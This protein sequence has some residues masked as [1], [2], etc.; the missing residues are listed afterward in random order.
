MKFLILVILFFVFSS[1][2]FAENI[3]PSKGIITT[4]NPHASRAALEIIEKGGNSIDAAVAVQLVLTLTEPQATGIGGGAFML[5]WDKK[6]SKL[7][8]IDGREKAPSRVR[9]DLFLDSKGNKKRFYPDAVV[10][11]QS[12]GVP[13]VIRLLEESHKKFGKLPWDELFSYAIN[14]AEN[15]FAVSPALN[16]ILG[17]LGPLKKIEPA[18]SLYYIENLDGEKEPVPV[19]YKLKN[20]EYSKT[21]K[22]L[23]KRGSRDFYEGET[24]KLIIDSI[25]KYNKE[26]V[27]SH[28]DLKNYK[29]V[30]REPLCSKY[31]KYNVCSMGPPS[32]G[33]L[34]ML[35]MLKLLEDFNIESLKPNSIDMIHLFSEVNRIAY[36]DRAYYMGDSDFINVPINGLLD[37]TYIKKRRNL[38]NKDYYSED[39]KEG[40]PEGY[41]N[42]EKNID[43]SKPST[44]HFVI[45]DK[46]GNA[47]SMTSTVEGPFG[48]HLMAGGFILNNELTD[49]SMLPEI[50]GKKIANR[51]E[52]NK[53]P[54]SSMTPTIIFK[55]NELYALTGSP[56]GTSII[57]YVTK[58]VLGII[59]WNLEPDEIVEL[60]H[61]MNKGNYTELEKDSVIENL[62]SELESKGHPVRVLKKRSGLHLAVKKEDGFIGSADPRREGLVIP[63]N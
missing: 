51:V 9:E 61:Y 22:R 44:S 59:D 42:F 30:W 33:G 3:T 38:I 2:S 18:A 46:E 37:D 23:S 26:A 43:I 60:P 58:S 6:S 54:M 25:K 36:A 57:N 16:S 31:R 56:G 5:Y 8:S 14:L 45:V 29:I 52:P 1:S 53:R 28:S 50:N 63:I 13:G 41:E 15:G 32:S 48:S 47:V 11:S 39:I 34:T 20:I 17:Y 4:S 19:G 40:M 49:F 12:I 55:D 62:K 10:G 35:M 27:L 24:A 7:F 21:L